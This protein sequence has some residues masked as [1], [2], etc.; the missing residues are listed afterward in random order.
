MTPTPPTASDAE[1]TLYE[2]GP[3]VIST[4]GALLFSIVTLG[5]ALLFYWLRSLGTSYRVTTKRI[6][7]EHGV[8]SKRLE[9]VDLYRIKDYVVERPFLQ[10]LVG[11]GNLV[12][13]TLDQT[14]P[15]VEIRGVKAD[16][17]VLYE[18][19]RAAAEAERMRRGVRLVDYE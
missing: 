11:T 14:N 2:G 8:F 3:A 17:T 6:I 5:I 19:V 12:V 1:Q 7:I 10:R 4:A 9:Q 18:Q 16:V 15:T 13:H